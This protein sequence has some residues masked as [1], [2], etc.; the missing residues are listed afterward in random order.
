MSNYLL[1]SEYFFF[2]TKQYNKKF[3]VQHGKN[4]FFIYKI[5]IVNN[6]TKMYFHKNN[7]FVRANAYNNS[8]LTV[9]KLFKLRNYYKFFSFF[10][11]CFLNNLN[12]FFF[13]FK[14]FFFD[15]LNFMT[16]V[17]DSG[18]FL[19]FSPLLQFYQEKKNR[20]KF[21]KLLRLIFKKF[22][23]SLLILFDYKYSG[24]FL[25]LLFDTNLPIVGFTYLNSKASHFHYYLNVGK[26]NFLLKYA[27]FQQVFNIYVLAL[28]L[29]NIAA[30]KKF[31]IKYKYFYLL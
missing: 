5:S 19:Y 10:F 18:F 21:F 24:F 9:T 4:F 14:L 2:N 27:V 28:N 13:S 20:K 31:F 17:Y 16:Y 26:S 30:C 3:K 11:H 7:M 15:F 23:P 29:N 12:L 8:V 25:K 22:K 6:F 1:I